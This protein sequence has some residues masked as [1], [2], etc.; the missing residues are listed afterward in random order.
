MCLLISVSAF[1]SVSFTDVDKDKWYYEAVEYVYTNGVMVGV[2]KTE[3]K[4]DATTNRAMVV[5]VL[6]R[7]AKA[8]FS[9]C[10]KTDFVDVPVDSWYGKSVIWAQKNG[11]VAGVDKTHFEPMKDITR[12]QMCVMLSNFLDFMKLSTPNRTVEPFSDIDEVSSWAVKAVERLRK[13]GIVNGKENNTFDPQGNATRAEIAQ[14]ILSSRLADI[15]VTPDGEKPAGNPDDEGKQAEGS[16]D[17]KKTNTDT[18]S[19][20]KKSIEE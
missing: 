15:S 6:A 3:F 7:L 16:A 17:G 4:P 9:D 13:A 8:D 5:A 1:A 12:E 11:I 18:S 14:I 2:T 10:T 19:D 20:K